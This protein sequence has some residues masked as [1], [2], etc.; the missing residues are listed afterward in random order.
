M[1]LDSLCDFRLQLSHCLNYSGREHS[2]F[3]ATVPGGRLQ[4]QTP[5][6]EVVPVQSP[7]AISL[8]CRCCSTVTPSS[9]SSY[10]FPADGHGVPWKPEDRRPLPRLEMSERD[11]AEPASKYRAERPTW[12]VHVRNYIT[13][14]WEFVILQLLR[15]EKDTYRS[16]RSASSIDRF[17]KHSALI[18]SKTIII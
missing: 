10:L 11:R 13:A 14:D 9:A 12:P 1:L 7:T 18:L 15:E 3:V 5:T 4:H 8:C 6:W 16:P 2:Y 17:W